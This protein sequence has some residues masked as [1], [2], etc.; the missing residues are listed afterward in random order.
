MVRTKHSGTGIFFPFL[1]PAQP[2]PHASPWLLAL[3]EE[4]LEG[5]AGQGSAGVGWSIGLAPCCAGGPGRQWVQLAPCFTMNSCP[6]PS[7]DEV[8]A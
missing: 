6:H 8:A 3:S 1:F 5:A 7:R 4:G 2:V